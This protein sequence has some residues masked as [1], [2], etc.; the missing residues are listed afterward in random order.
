MTTHDLSPFSG[1]DEKAIIDVLAYRSNEQRQEIYRLFKTM[2]GKVQMICSNFHFNS[3]LNTRK[4][5]KCDIQ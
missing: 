2:Y 4:T 1:T 5:V 3:K